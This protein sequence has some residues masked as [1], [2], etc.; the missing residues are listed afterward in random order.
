MNDFFKNLSPKAAFLAGIVAAVMVLC[1]IGF[2]VL[3]TFFLKGTGFSFGDI[4][5]KTDKANET[6][7]NLGRDTEPPVNP[8][9]GTVRVGTISSADHIRGDLNAPI[10]VVEYSDT[11]CPFCK[12]FHPTMQQVFSDYGGQVAWVYRHFPLDSLHQK[13]RQEAEATECAAE[14]GGNDAFWAY[15]DRIYEITPSNDGLP[16][17]ELPVI[18]SD[19]GLNRSAFEECLTS[20]RHAEKVQSHY[21]DAVASGGTGTPYSVVVSGDQQIPV[22]GAVPI[23]Q[24]KSIIDSLL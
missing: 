9:A 4:T 23:T 20:G 15:V 1:T 21:D 5:S 16:E 10:K 18:A 13:A 19:I 17:S 6:D 12:R 14:L 11:E 3:L 7:V 24:L 22:N 2:I 8:S